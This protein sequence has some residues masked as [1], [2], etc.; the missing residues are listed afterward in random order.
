MLTLAVHVTLLQRYPVKGSLALGLHRPL[1]GY[2][3]P[4]VSR[5]PD[6]ETPLESG[7]A[8]L[9]L[10]AVMHL[11]QPVFV[12]LRSNNYQNAGASVMG[13]G[14]LQGRH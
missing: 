6:L 2:I 13:E 8:S 7:K 11:P 10:Y 5:R 3:G 14:R 9:V 12:D 1:L 4:H